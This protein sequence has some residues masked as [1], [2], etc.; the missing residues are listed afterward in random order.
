MA[1]VI[2]SA[3]I[4]SLLSALYIRKQQVLISYKKESAFMTAC[5]KFFLC[6]TFSLSSYLDTPTSHDSLS[7]PVVHIEKENKESGK[8]SAA[9]SDEGRGFIAEKDDSKKHG[10]LWHGCGD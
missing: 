3:R 8:Q 10:L 5:A 7:V 1:H 2:D 9:I 4:K 6:P